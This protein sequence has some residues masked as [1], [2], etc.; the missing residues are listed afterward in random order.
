MQI[1]MQ[2]RCNCNKLLAV[3]YQF[4]GS[5]EVK[6]PRCKRH[7]ILNANEHRKKGNAHG[8]NRL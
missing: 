1:K 8:P 2:H 5:V 6:C 4:S 7:N 3:S